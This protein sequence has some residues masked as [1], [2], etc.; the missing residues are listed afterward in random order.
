M[1][2]DY[3]LSDDILMKFKEGYFT[4]ER[5]GIVRKHQ[6]ICEEKTA[7]D[8]TED[9]ISRATFRVVTFLTTKQQAQIHLQLFKPCAET[10]QTPV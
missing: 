4:S 6:S 8:V 9:S 3:L 7:T 2:R 10:Q 1:G 5:D